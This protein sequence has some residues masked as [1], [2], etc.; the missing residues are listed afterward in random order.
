MVQ[1]LSAPKALGNKEN[2]GGDREGFG[3]RICA[4]D[5]AP[6]L[7]DYG[8]MGFVLPC[9]VISAEP[10]AGGISKDWIPAFAGMTR[11]G[12]YSG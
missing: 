2:V 7:K 10:R 5:L 6:A 9:P 8:S 3:I 11:T 12:F 1:R 4:G